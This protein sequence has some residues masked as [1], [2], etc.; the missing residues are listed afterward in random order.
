MCL[1]GSVLDCPYCG[2]KMSKHNHEPT[3]TEMLDWAEKHLHDVSQMYGIPACLWYN[4]EG[5]LK[6]VHINT[7]ASGKL[8]FRAAIK[9]AMADSKGA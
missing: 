5:R 6:Y 3:D 8:A 4:S 1:L 9:R 2:E 7:N